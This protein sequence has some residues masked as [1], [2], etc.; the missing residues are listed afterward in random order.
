MVQDKSVT[1][2]VQTAVL[3]DLERQD[4]REKP[5]NS[6]LAE[7]D[8]KAIL[9]EWFKRRSLM[10]DRFE[11]EF[12]IWSLTSCVALDNSFPGSQFSDFSNEDNDIVY[13]MG[14]V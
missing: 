5:C 14:L 8:K 2:I 10:S 9:A 3:H 11:L 4:N 13:C 6:S 7:L 12:C 1:W